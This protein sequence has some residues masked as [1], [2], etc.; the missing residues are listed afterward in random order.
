LWSATTA[1]AWSRTSALFP[2]P[3]CGQ[4]V[5]RGRCAALI[6]TAP[7]EAAQFACNAVVLDREVVLPAGCPKLCGALAEKG[8]RTH[9]LAMG[10]FIKAGAPASA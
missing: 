1:F 5:I 7:E 8:Y 10:E 3:V 6:E 4:R 2:R 9:E